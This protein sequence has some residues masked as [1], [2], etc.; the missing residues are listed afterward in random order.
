[1]RTVIVVGERVFQQRTNECCFPENLALK[2]KF[3]ME[4]KQ[5]S[6][7]HVGPD[8]FKSEIDQIICRCH[9]TTWT[10]VSFKL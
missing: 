7:F 5:N 2:G 1:M 4:W 3:V 9:L 10:N 6:F 8:V